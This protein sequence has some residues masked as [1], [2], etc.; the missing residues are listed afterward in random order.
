[1]K[2][3]QKFRVLAM[4]AFVLTILGQSALAESGYNDIEK[5]WNKE[6]ITK[7]QSNNTI[8]GYEDGSFKPDNAVTRAEFSV[9][10]NRV[11]QLPAA[12]TSLGDFIDIS[13]KS[14]YANAV[15]QMKE[16]GIINGYEDGTFQ[17]N[18]YITRQEA[19]MLLSRAFEISG[20]DT[21]VLASYTDKSEVDQWARSAVAGLVQEGYLQGS[22]NTIKAK[23]NITRAELVALIENM[24]GNVWNSSQAAD[25]VE[26]NLVINSDAA[27]LND[28]TIK[29][30]LF[31][32]Q[33]IG[34]G[35]VDLNNV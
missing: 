13:A 31:L 23:N 2:I 11:F 7:W 21:N 29:G 24:A 18:K 9:I 12:T 30:D 6:N 16:A 1:M 35:Q 4:A 20:A 10:L 17:P 22:N 15:G 26:G 33:G 5:H 25:V 8:L 14:W 27:V 28:V 32:T 34:Q 3:M 19:C